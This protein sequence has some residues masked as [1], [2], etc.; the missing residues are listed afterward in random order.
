MDGKKVLLTLVTGL[1]LSMAAE[2]LAMGL[3]AKVLGKWYDA[4]GQVV[5]DIQ[6]DTVNGCP[7]EEVAGLA[8]G[9]SDFSCRGKIREAAGL[10][11]LPLVCE[12]LQKDSWHA[13]VFLGGDPHRGEKGRLLSRTP[14]PLHY[15]SVGGIGLDTPTGAVE[16]AYG[17]P[18]RLER[19]QDRNGHVV[20]EKWKY[21]R[22]GLELFLENQ[23]VRRIRIYREGDRKFDRSGLGCA[24]SLE[25]YAASY[26]FRN[27]PKAG[28]FAAYAIGHGEYLWF[29]DYPRSIQLNTYNN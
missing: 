26:G 27:V 9:S 14:E 7:V 3:P 29:D 28:Q 2:A 17:I 8:G 12:S 16:A 25:D 21:T 18:D 20:A 15:E 23:T 13:H 22:L 4:S 1:S 6:E 10:R 24:S 5:L 19:V 11:D